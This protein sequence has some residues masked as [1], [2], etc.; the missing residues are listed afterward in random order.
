[1]LPRTA[2]RNIAFQR[3]EKKLAFFTPTFAYGD[4]WALVTGV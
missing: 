4:P 3:L 2:E 1:M